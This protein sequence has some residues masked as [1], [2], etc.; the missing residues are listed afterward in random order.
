MAKKRFSRTFNFLASLINGNKIRAH[1]APETREKN[2]SSFNF[3]AS[4]INGNNI[5]AGGHIGPA[6]SFNFLA[7]LINGNLWNTQLP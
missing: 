2:Q 3:L 7:S 6:P 4:L 5:S 1:S